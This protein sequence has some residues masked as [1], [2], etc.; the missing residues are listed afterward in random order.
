MQLMSIPDVSLPHVTVFPQAKDPMW[1]QCTPTGPG[2]CQ[3]MGQPNCPDGK[4]IGG[5]REWIKHFF[6]AKYCDNA[7]ISEKGCPIANYVI[8]RKTVE[9]KLFVITKNTGHKSIKW[10]VMVITAWEGIGSGVADDASEQLSALEQFGLPVTRGN[11]Q[12]KDVQKMSLPSKTFWEAA[13]PVSSVGTRYTMLNAVQKELTCNS[14]QYQ[15]YHVQVMDKHIAK[16]HTHEPFV[17]E[18]WPPLHTVPE[19]KQQQRRA[20]STSRARSTLRPRSRPRATSVHF[21]E[22]VEEVCFKSV[23]TPKTQRNSEDEQ[24]RKNTD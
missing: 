15:T 14:C 6:E 21:D 19:A 16:S 8:P 22:V 5:D 10:A 20:R 11:H 1:V 7:A 24:V 17:N 13:P 4:T 18:V 2:C 3:F 23:N 9:E 12:N